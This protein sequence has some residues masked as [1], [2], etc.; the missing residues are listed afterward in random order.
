MKKHAKLISILAAAAV[1]AGTG[2]AVKFWKKG[3]GREKTVAVPVTRG[4]LKVTVLATA[5]VQPQNRLEIKVPIAGRLEE[6]L[7]KE[8]AAVRKGEV[9]GWMSSTERAALLDAALAKGKEEFD[10]WSQIYKAIPLIAPMGGVIIARNMEPGQTV[11]SQDAPL[12]M[13][14]RLVVKA[15]VDETDISRIRVGQEAEGELD[16]YPG[17]VNPAGVSHVAFEA[18]TVNNVTTYEVDVLPAAVP[19][20]MR[21]GMT[22]NVT[23]IIQRKENVLLL[24]QE[25]VRTGEDGDFVLAAGNGEGAGGQK[26]GKPVRKMIRAGLSD[27]KHVEVLEGLEEGERVMAAS[28]NWDSN[29]SSG[30]TNPLSPFRGR[31]ASSRGSQSGGGRSR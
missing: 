30:G 29:S 6:V 13:S 12:V 18:K 20:Y 1:L 9:L 15:Q 25:A 28:M 14:D 17:R 31:R 2:A 3:S 8:G 21:S 5:V 27:G 10:H 19:P 16:A 24:P 11:T 26:K 23:F 4:G 22:A 7:V